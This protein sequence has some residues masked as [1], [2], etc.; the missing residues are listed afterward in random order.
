MIAPARTPRDTIV[1]VGDAVTRTLQ[2]A[3]VGEKLIRAR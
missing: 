3:D 2:P 1:A